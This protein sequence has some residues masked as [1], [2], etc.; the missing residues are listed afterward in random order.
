MHFGQ[1]LSMNGDPL[2]IM[3]VTSKNDRDVKMPEIQSL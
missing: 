2:M 3:K 1:I